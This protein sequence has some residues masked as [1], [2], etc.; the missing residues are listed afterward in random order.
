MAQLAQVL[1]DMQT[2]PRT[3]LDEVLA[4]LDENVMMA[5]AG[6]VSSLP[7]PTLREDAAVALRGLM[8]PK[9]ESLRKGRD[10]A[11]R[12][13]LGG[14]ASNRA[15]L[16][17]YSNVAERLGSNSTVCEVG[18]NVGH[19]AAVWLSANPS[20]TL[21]TFDY[22][23]D[24]VAQYSLQYLNRTFKGRIIAHRGNSHR[25]V[26]N[27]SI[28]PGC[29]LVHVDG[30]HTYTGTLMDA[31][32]LMPKSRP[33]ALFL[34]DDQCLPSSCEAHNLYSLGPTLATCDLVKAASLRF[35]DA[36]Y[37]GPRQWALFEL[38]SPPSIVVSTLPCVPRCRLQF[39]LSLPV[40]TATLTWFRSAQPSDNR[41]PLCLC[42]C[43][44]HPHRCS[45]LHTDLAPSGSATL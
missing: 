31:V 42:S 8:L 45:C 32:N 4:H 43:P 41:P 1:H 2:P 26:P 20:I 25:T 7:G 13:R 17:Y 37:I 16:A 35:L 3:F 6:A 29:S 5:S 14:I 38:A 11:I 40:T 39:N 33:G 21:H 34:F 18:F 30:E 15:Q 27:A 9:D 36:S 19:S 22:F 12:L 10:V 24:R 44:C 23:R 28:L